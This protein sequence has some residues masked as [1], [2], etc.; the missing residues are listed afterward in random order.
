MNRNLIISD[1]YSNLL[2]GYE[3]DKD[4]G[5]LWRIYDLSDTGILGNIYCGYVENVISN[6]EGAFVIFGDNKKGFLPLK[7]CNRKIKRG[8][9]LPVE[10]VGDRIKSKEYRLSAHINLSTSDVILTFGTCGIGISKKIKD[11]NIKNEIKENFK[12]EAKNFGLLFRTSAKTKTLSELKSEVDFL[13]KELNNLLEMSSHAAKGALLYK[14]NRV[15]SICD[16][17]YAH[18][19][20]PIL[21]DN[22]KIAQRLLS[23]GLEVNLQ[24]RATISLCNRY[25]ILKYLDEAVSSKVYLKSGG[26]LIIEQTETLTAIDVNTGKATGAKRNEAV[27]KTNREAALEA[28]RQIQLRNISGI[29]FIDFINTNDEN[30]CEYLKNYIRHKTLNDYLQCEVGGLTKFGLLEMAREKCEKPLKDIL[31]GTR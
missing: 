24:D 27:L 26:Y 15:E 10:V 28:I 22:P 21:T 23:A 20:S 2:L 6:L 19:D 31:N 17:F 5:E 9:M 8:D 13:K 7:T 16:E 12:E 29:I 30:E 11:D 25:S 14:K 1:F 4:T 18:N 3:I